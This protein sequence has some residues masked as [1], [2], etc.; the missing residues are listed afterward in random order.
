MILTVNII[1]I[2]YLIRKKLFL[3]Y[4]SISKD[5]FLLKTCL[6][7]NHDKLCMKCTVNT[8]NS[9]YV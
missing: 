3:I 2:T 4:L 5:L 6:T 8:Y 9:F 1:Y 7:D